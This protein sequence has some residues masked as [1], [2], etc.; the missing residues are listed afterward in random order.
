MKNGFIKVAAASPACTLARPRANAVSAE[1]AM[2]EAEEKGAKLLVLPEL[3]LTGSSVG[4][5]M[6]FSSLIREAEAALGSLLDRTADTRILTLIGLPVAYGGSIYS[7]AAVVFG[8]ELLGL[9]PSSYSDCFAPPLNENIGITLCKREVTFGT[10]QLFAAK[11]M[12]SFV[13]CAE[14]G[15][16]LFAC[17]SPFFDHVKAGATVVACPAALPEYSGAES[18]R[19]MLISSS[20]LRARC[21]YVLASAGEGESTTDFVYSGHCAVAEC[22]EIIAESTFAS[23]GTVISEIDCERILSTRR[24]DRSFENAADGYAVHRFS[25]GNTEKTALTRVYG[26]LPFIAEADISKV[27]DLQSRGLARRITASGAKTLVIGISGGLDSCLALLVAVR[28]CEM[29]KMDPSSVLA[30]T[31]PCFGTSGRTRSNA[32]L[33]CRELKVSFKEVDIRSAVLGHFKDIG[34]DGESHDVTFE[35]SQARERT[36]VL[37]DVANLTGG[38]VVGTGDLSELALGF[39]TYNGDHMSM[40]AVN[41]SLPKTLIRAVVLYAAG[42]YEKMGKTV[43]ADALTDVVKTPVS[44]ELLPPSEDKITQVTEDIVGPYELHDFFIYHLLNYG[45][46]AEK[47]HRLASYAFDGEYDSETVKKWLCV[48]MK[49]FMTQQFKRSCMPDGPKV[50]SVSLSPRNAF[51]MPSDVGYGVFVGEAESL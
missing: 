2:R 8:G 23:C 47:L 32:E 30:I 44:P 16:D 11:D 28:A 5:L 50:T 15:N 6:Y 37:M 41:S 43:L 36:Q 14:L 27:I 49:R 18:K 13:L 26:K 19:K 24:R 33:L 7:C 25:F 20:S 51:S 35:N 38:I 22:G 31:M 42:E 1:A 3:F 45:Y 12:P 9:I 29:C 39:A 48:F 21:G 4:D 46:S 34:H 10:K 17:F 40:Y